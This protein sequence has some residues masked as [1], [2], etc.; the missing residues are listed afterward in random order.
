MDDLPFPAYDMVHGFAKRYALPL[1]GYPKHPGASIISS[2]G[3]LYRCNFCDRSVFKNSFRFNA[4]EYTF[5]LIKWLNTDFGVKHVIFYD[6]LFTLNRDRVT[7]LC[8]LLRKNKPTVSF[9]CIVRAGHISNELIRELQS[10]RCWMVNVG[11]ES[12]DQDVLDS[13]KEG[14]TLDTIRND[15]NRL[16]NAG[17]WVKGLFMMGFPGET[18]LS[19]QKTIDFACSLPCKDVNVT[20]F[21]PF[22]GSPVAERI[23]ELGAFDGRPANWKN[24]D[25]VKFVFVPKEIG[26]KEMLEKYYREFIGR[27]YK[28]PFMRKVYQKMLFQSP[29]SYWRLIKHAAVFWRY[30]RGINK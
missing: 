16:H 14:L 19:I 1:F 26:S 18:E 4:P 20:T 27:F 28:R 15:I 23:H 22:P 21:T 24:M 25:C 8:R 5:E 29:H 2:R 6:D 11:V 17:I 13:F 12:G 30:A 10:S 9:N 3:C 7:Q